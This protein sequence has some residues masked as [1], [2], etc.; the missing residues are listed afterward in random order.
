VTPTQVVRVPLVLFR[1][2]RLV[3]DEIPILPCLLS[4]TS[5][6]DPVGNL[7][8]PSPLPRSDNVGIAKYTL[9]GQAGKG[10]NLATHDLIFELMQYT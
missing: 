5:V 1:D 3:A 7:S 4:L 6:R 10:G 2:A 9:Q 8:P